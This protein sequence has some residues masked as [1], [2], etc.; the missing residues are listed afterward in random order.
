MTKQN[1]NTSTGTRQNTKNSI[2]SIRGDFYNHFDN[3]FATF[4]TQVFIWSFSS[5]R[6]CYV[7]LYEKIKC[8]L[9]HFSQHHGHTTVKC[10]AVNFLHFCPFPS[11]NGTCRI[12]TVAN[13]GT[14]VPWN[15]HIEKTNTKGTTKNKQELAET[16]FKYCLFDVGHTKC[17]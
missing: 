14:S 7:M 4:F 1:D 16:I 3:G 5:F 13:D 8:H 10:H 11:Q 6:C 17:K 2:F 9:W 15:T 12:H